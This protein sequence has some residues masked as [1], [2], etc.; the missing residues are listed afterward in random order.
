MSIN[1]VSLTEGDSGTTAFTFTVSMSGSNSLGTSVDY[2]TADGTATADD[3]VATNGTLTWA[4]GDTSSKTISV[5]VNGDTMVET[6]ETF[7]VNLSSPT[8]ATFSKSQGGGTI[9]N[10]D[11][12]LGIM[13]TDATKAEGNSGTTPFTF[14]VSRSGLTTGAT[15]VNYAVTRSET[16]P[17]DSEDFAGALPSG[18]VSFAAG[19][20]SQN[21]DN[22]RQRRPSSGA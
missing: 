6:D 17:A 12:A 14:T 18:Q 3:Y 13:A 20:T 10:D 11:I 1:D 21:S 2:A 8:N 19:V 7:Y 16:D 5:A 9:Q 15:T 4:A 22:Q